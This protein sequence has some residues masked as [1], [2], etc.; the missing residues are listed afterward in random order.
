MYAT[1]QRFGERVFPERRL[2][3][4]SRGDVIQLSLSTALQMSVA[5]ACLTAATS[6]VGYAA[7]SHSHARSAE[8]AMV[9]QLKAMQVA[10]ATAQQA[11][12]AA[13]QQV[14]TLAA[15]HA[16]QN[17][18]SA[19]AAQMARR[20]AE[21]QDTLAATA[22]QQAA[23]ASEKGKLQ[24]KVG[25]L[26]QEKDKAA[27]SLAEERDKLR[28][29]VAELETR[30]H[31]PGAPS[32]PVLR[33]GQNAE[34]SGGRFD[35]N[36]FMSTL[37][38][39]A[40]HQGGVGGPYVAVGA[41]RPG[42][43]ISPEAQAMLKTLP[44][45]APLDNYTLESRFGVRVDPINGR[46][47][48]HTGLDLSASYKSPVFSTSSGTVVFAGY[49]AAYGKMVEIDHGNGIHTRY[50]HLNRLMVNAGQHIAKH[51]EIGLLGSTGR[52]TGPHVHYEV[53]VNGVPQNPEKFL[54]AGRQVTL[55]KTGE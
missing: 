18:A 34:V 53:T 30:L 52:S 10:L 41:T 4:Q 3:I 48:M 14:Q 50:G 17:A 51:T 2:A 32:V 36:S 11:Q 37:G 33:G 27:H 19:D 22:Q 42:P 26:E 23:L 29:K 28:Q 15:D 35:L 24:S 13:A 8:R 7:W 49:A 54:E 20:I 31:Q 43:A 39:G 46:E 5:F 12:Q 1:L 9:R 45:S 25:E 21:L 38:I 16:A 47:A 40:P 6:G 55:V 44:L